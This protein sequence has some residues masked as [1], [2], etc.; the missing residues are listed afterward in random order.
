MYLSNASSESPGKY[1][2]FSWKGAAF[3]A[4]HK[5]GLQ[6]DLRIMHLFCRSEFLMKLGRTIIAMKTHTDNDCPVN[7]IRSLL[8]YGHFYVPW[9]HL[10]NFSLRLQHLF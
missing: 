1:R 9:D 2:A 4:E 10:G 6:D 5:L 3:C 7:A 8:K